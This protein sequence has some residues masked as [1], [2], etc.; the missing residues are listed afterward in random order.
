M[1]AVLPTN[2]LKRSSFGF[3]AIAVSPNMVSGLVVAIVIKS[4]VPSIG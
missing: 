2:D 1:V 4:E 3:T